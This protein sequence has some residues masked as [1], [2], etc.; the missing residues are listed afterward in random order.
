[1][2]TEP[3]LGVITVFAGNFAP[4]N[5]MFCQ[6]QLLAISQYD[7]LYALIGTTYGGD[8]QTTFALPDFRG[9][10]AVH[11]GQA[12]G[13]SNFYMIGQVGGTENITLT[14]ANLPVHN[15]PFIS[16]T[17]NQRVSSNAGDQGT[18]ASNVPAVTTGINCYNSSGTAAMAATTN[19]TSSAI[20]GGSQPF[21]NAS[22]V[23]AMNYI[24]AVQGIFPSR[25]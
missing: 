25:N 5:Y 22:P 18:P 20:A 24:I 12:P 7:A 10:V 15:H 9:R 14:S 1:M 16:L 21:N 19:N 2:F 13:I 8:G 23:L 17:G 11:Q 6:G 3:Y 4:V